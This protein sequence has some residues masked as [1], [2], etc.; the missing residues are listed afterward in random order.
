M[1]YKMNKTGRVVE[2][3]INKI[4][5]LA[6]A[7]ALQEG[8]MSPEDKAKLDSMGIHYN[9]THYWNCLV[10]YIP[11]AGEI[12]IYSDYKTVDVEG[13]TKYVPGIKIGTGNAY[14]Q[15]LA[16]ILGNEDAEVF[17]EHI[18]DAVRHITDEERAYWNNKL[19]VDDNSEV[20]EETLVFNRN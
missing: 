8:T 6:P 14:V 1:P 10:G 13:Q 15:D 20:V 18:E 9:T 11:K 3:A 12:I 17:F 5:A 4:L 16:F 2:E 7:T 19:N